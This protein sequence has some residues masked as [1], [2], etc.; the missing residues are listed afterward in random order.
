M[1]CMENNL[2][3]NWHMF[4]VWLILF[5]VHLKLM[6]YCNQL[7]LPIKIKKKTSKLFSEFCWFKVYLR[8]VIYIEK[9]EMLWNL[10]PHLK[11]VE[12]D[13]SKFDETWFMEHCNKVWWWWNRNFKLSVMILYSL[14][15]K[16]DYPL[17]LWRRIQKL[18]SCRGDQEY[19]ANILE[20]REIRQGVCEHIT[21]KIVCIFWVL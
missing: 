21:L 18:F 9:L 4:Y 5:A 12:S 8:L 7:L 13:F 2:K 11:K 6:W 19:G 17:S 14:D 15:E 20:K 10:T 16:L 3:K 1:A